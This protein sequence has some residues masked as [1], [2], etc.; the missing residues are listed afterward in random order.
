MLIQT[1]THPRTHTKIRKG[2]HDVTYSSIPMPSKSYDREQR[3]V[4]SAMGSSDMLSG[5]KRMHS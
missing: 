4:T 1:H 3:F 5:P 2:T